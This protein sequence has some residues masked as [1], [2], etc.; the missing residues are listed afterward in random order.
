MTAV[1][2]AGPLPSGRRPLAPASGQP[3]PAAP[4][5]LARR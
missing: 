2:L 1:S 4:S 5:I 3:A